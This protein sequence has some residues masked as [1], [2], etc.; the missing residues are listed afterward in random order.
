[1]AVVVTSTA[2]VAD[3]RSVKCVAVGKSLMMTSRN[4]SF[5]SLCQKWGPKMAQQ[6]DPNDGNS[7]SHQFFLILTNFG[8][9]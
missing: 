3:V 8:N 2:S 1:M 4:L 5:T 9:G 6:M 7:K